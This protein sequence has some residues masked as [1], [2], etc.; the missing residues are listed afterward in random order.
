MGPSLGIY[1][2]G[3]TVVRLLA[4]LT[5]EKSMRSNAKPEEAWLLRVQTCVYGG[6]VGGPVAGPSLLLLEGVRDTG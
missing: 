2:L 4:I 3:Q 6:G 5:R 1:A